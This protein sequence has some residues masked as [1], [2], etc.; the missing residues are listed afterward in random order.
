MSQPIG[1]RQR[2]SLAGR[3]AVAVLLTIGFYGLALLIA[4]ALF[5]VPVLEWNLIHR[6]TGQLAA[7]C[8]IGGGLILQ[9]PSAIPN[10]CDR[11]G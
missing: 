3:A 5:A 4:I 2:R 11:R 1:S 7:A 6:V 10:S 8:V 9:H